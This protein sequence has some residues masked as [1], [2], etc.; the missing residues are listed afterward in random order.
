MSKSI[1]SKD[2]KFFSSW[3]SWFLVLGSWLLVLGSWFLGNGSEIITPKG[4]N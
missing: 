1:V 2:I 3:A 4:G